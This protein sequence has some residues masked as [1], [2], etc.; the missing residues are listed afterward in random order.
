MGGVEDELRGAVVLLELDDRRVGVVALEVEDVP[1][2]R[3][4]PAVDRLVVVAHDAQVAVAPRRAP[5][6]TGTAAGSCPGT[7]PRGG[8]ASAPGTAPGP[9][10]PRSNRRTASSRRSSKSRA[11]ASREALRVAGGEPGDD[12]LA[13]VDG[14]LGEE[15]SASS[16]SFLARLIAP[17][18]AAGRNSPVAGRSCSREDPL[19][20]AAAGRPCR[21][22]RSG[23][24]ARWPRRRAAGRGRTARGTSRPRR[25]CPV[26]PTS[27]WIRSRS[28]PAARF[29]NV[30]ARI[31]RGWTR[32][33]ADQ[34]RDP[35]GDDARLAR[36]G[37]GEDQ[38][39][40]RRWS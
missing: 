2:V 37:A 15:P 39:R 19:H 1:E 38:Q 40:A 36:P 3:A 24:P 11:P 30:T 33:H 32:L 18:I 13:V 21:R 10:A 5:G 35:V 14:V 7:R 34:V 29:V 23:G 26:S 25:P 6:P 12:P 27:A 16:M 22:S 31:R 9:R 20:Q 28:S 4:A 17:R 8:S